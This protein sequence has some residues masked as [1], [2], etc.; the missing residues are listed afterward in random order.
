MYL[1][2]LRINCQLLKETVSLRIN[3]IRMFIPSHAANKALGELVSCTNKISKIHSFLKK[4]L[5][6]ILKYKLRKR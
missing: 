1:K 2:E 6:F 3:E 4:L 5:V